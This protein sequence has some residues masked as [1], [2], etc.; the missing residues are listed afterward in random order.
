MWVRIYFLTMPQRIVRAL[1]S[2]LCIVSMIT[3]RARHARKIANSRVCS[4]MLNKYYGS[5]VDIYMINHKN[6]GASRTFTINTSTHK[7][8]RRHDITWPVRPINVAAYTAIATYF[9][10]SKDY[11]PMSRAGLRDIAG[12]IVRID[13]DISVEQALA[14]RNIVI[15]DKIVKGYARINAGIARIAEK[16]HHGTDILSLS[17][18]FDFPPLSLLRSIFMRLGYGTG[19]LHSVFANKKSPSTVLK[20]RDVEQYKKAEEYD[21]ESVINQQAAAVVA[22]TNEEAFVAYIRGLGIALQTQ[23]SLTEQ[24]MNDCGRAVLT[25]D[26][27]FIDEVYIN[28]Q[29]VYWIDYKDYMGTNVGFLLESNTKQAAKYMKEWG[30][31]ALCYHRSFVSNVSIPD[32]L[33]LDV[34]ALPLHLTT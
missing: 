29:R 5:Y 32:T 12:L 15:K 4:S 28:N 31:G 9:K 27:L 22:A 16:Y 11:S 6:L 18:R 23:D 34:A 21:A 1:Y 33:L 20:G 3:L 25:P 13:P 26:I 17:K 8:V 10:S 2:H 14:I 19:A 30:P 7:T 24:Q